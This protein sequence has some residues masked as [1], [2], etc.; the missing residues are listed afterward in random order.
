MNVY[1]SGI[2]GLAMYSLFISGET[3]LEK[4]TKIHIGSHEEIPYIL[5][6][7]AYPLDC[8]SIFKNF[9]SSLA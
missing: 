6:E 9:E 2:I 4:L 3:I 7:A 5:Y 8:E 1:F